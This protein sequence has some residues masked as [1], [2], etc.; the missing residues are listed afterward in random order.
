M[1]KTVDIEGLSLSRGERNL[2]RG[3]SLRLS[4]GEAVALT[5]ANGAGKTSL[6]RA[7]AGFIRPDAGTITFGGADGEALD[8]EAARQGGVH[9]LGHLEGLKPTRTARQEFDFQTAW[10]GGSDAAREAATARLSLTPLLDLET[11]KLSAGQKRRLSLARL[12]AAPRALWLLDEPLAPL[13]ERWRAVAAELMAA[14]LASG[15]MIL[16]AVHDPLP[17]PARNLDLGGLA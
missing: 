2:F 10:L 13:D 15:G 7:V 6:L 17:V 8:A 11:R 4:A 14:H 9:L 1:L 12:V 16:A 5:G 3:L